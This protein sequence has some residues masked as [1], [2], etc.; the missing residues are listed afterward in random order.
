MIAA[1]VELGTPAVQLAAVL[2]S[3][4]TDPF[5]EVWARAAKGAKSAQERREQAISRS[6]VYFI[7]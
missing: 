6:G 3:V 7:T 2:Q 5:Q 1:V 4:L